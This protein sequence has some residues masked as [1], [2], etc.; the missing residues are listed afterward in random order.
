MPHMEDRV[1]HLFGVS[2]EAKIAVADTLSSVIAKAGL[3]LVNC[4][5]N[6]GKILLCG[7]GGFYDSDA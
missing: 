7:N 4:L 3:R 6:D 1:R 5:L 2:I